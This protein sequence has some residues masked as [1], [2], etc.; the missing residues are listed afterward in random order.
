MPECANLADC[1][2]AAGKQ[3]AKMFARPFL[4]R[5]CGPL[6]ALLARPES[7]QLAAKLGLFRQ[8]WTGSSATQETR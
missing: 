5:D 7:A 3:G 1:L 2:A 6:E 8:Q 4:I